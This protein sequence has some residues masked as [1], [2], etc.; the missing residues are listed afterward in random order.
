TKGLVLGIYSKE[1]EDDVP[2]FTS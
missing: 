2:Q 1:K